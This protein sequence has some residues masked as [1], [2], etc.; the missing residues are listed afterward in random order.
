MISNTFLIIGFLHEQT[1]ISSET[2]RNSLKKGPLRACPY[3]SYKTVHTTNLKVHIR[4]HTGERP[5]VCPVCL[6]GFK[7][8]Q[9]VQ[10]HMV[11]HN[12]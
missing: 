8:K 3:C 12:E 6:K 4:K 5:F 10:C 1:E 11:G 9:A 7:T 2:S